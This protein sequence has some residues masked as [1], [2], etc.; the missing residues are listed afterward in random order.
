MDVAR[1]C[2][3]CQANSLNSNCKLK[4][5]ISDSISGLVMETN[6]PKDS[7]NRLNTQTKDHMPDTHP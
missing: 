4:F 7:S 2:P 6:R 3:E 1:F 5:W